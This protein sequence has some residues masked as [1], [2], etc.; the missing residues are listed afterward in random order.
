MATKRKSIYGVKE[1]VFS[2]G[3]IVT[4]FGKRFIILSKTGIL[5]PQNY[6]SE[7]LAIAQVKKMF[8]KAK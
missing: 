6:G 2:N 4:K 3:T 5:Y 7:K 8:P 1:I